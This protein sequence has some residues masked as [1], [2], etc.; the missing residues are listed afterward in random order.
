MTVF[1]LIPVDV[2]LTDYVIFAYNMQDNK[3]P[4]IL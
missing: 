4:I 2:I 3:Y 1:F